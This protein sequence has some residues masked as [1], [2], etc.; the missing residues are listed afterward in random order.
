MQESSC[1][2][3][4]A[5]QACDQV[6]LYPDLDKSG[7]SIAKRPEW[8]RFVQRIVELGRAVIAV[9][10]QSRTFRNTTEALDFYALME[11]LPE[12]HVVFKI[13]HFER[14]PAGE[15]TWTTMAAAHTMERKM[16]GAKIRD[17]KRY[18]A[19]RG[20]LVGAVPAGYRWAG[21]GRDRKLV[22]DE[23]VAP[24][25]RR[26]F[27]EYASGRWSTR[28]IAR[29]LNAEGVVLPRFTGGWRADTVAQLLGN[30]VYACLTTSTDGAE[31]GR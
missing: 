1:R 8:V 12:I 23:D 19:G 14:L 6:E 21:D 16:T 15:F 28:V 30:P 10:D 24:I 22:I 7:R 17:A 4:P 13:G 3:L 20:E 18:A 25:V 11:R 9:Y 2:A 27:E 31:K 29:R 5:V 26:V